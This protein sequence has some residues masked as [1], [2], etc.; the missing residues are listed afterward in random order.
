MKSIHKKIGLFC[1]VVILSQVPLLFA[2]KNLSTASRL[3]KATKITDIK[4]QQKDAGVTIII[5]GNGPMKPKVYTWSNLIVID[6]P[7]VTFNA[8]V[9]VKVVSPVKKVRTGKHKEKTRL[10]FYLEEMKKFDVSARQNTIIIALKNTAP[11]LKSTGSH[12]TAGQKET[13]QEQKKSEIIEKREIN[14]VQIETSTS[15]IKESKGPDAGLGEAYIDEKISTD[16]IAVNNTAPHIPVEEQEA[17][18]EQQKPEIIEKEGIEPVNADTSVAAGTVKESKGAEIKGKEADTGKE[19]STDSSGKEYI[20]GPEDVLDI[21][22]WG[23]DD[24]KRTVEVSQEGAFTFPLI[25]KVYA[26]GLTVFE[27]EQQLKKRLAEGYLKDPQVSITVSKYKNKKVIIL[28][29]VRKPGSY[30]IKGRTHILEFI[31]E[32]EGLTDRAGSIITIV[33]PQLSPGNDNSSP[34]PEDAKGSKTIEVNL[35]NMTAGASDDSFFVQEGDSIYISKA[36]PIFVTGEVNKPGEFK[37]EKHLS[38]HHAISLA[39]GPTRKGA[40]NRVKIYR[41]ENGK[42]KRFKPS[43]SDEVMPYDIVQV[44]ESY[45]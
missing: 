20:I 16:S 23:N 29:E 41:S 40:L 32:A 18:R 33:R 31:S 9:P 37:W 17:P 28:G 2:A 1:L 43:L 3:L 13:P 11:A 35:D 21:Q 39:G 38:V 27:L 44:P 30:V 26:K 4:F 42:E 25:D 45:F 7:D 36:P 6:I 10:V 8:E 34:L 15:V 5:K 12:I 19:I 22:V 24:L 14:P